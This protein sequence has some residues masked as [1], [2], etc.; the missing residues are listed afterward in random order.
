MKKNGPV[1][2]AIGSSAVDGDFTENQKNIIEF[3]TDPFDWWLGLV[4][5]FAG[6]NHGLRVGVC[7]SGGFE[8]VEIIGKLP[9]SL[10]KGLRRHA[11]WSERDYAI[12][13]VMRPDGYGPRYELH[14]MNDLLD[15]LVERKV[16]LG[17]GK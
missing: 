8:L 16:F 4:D 10:R 3:Q 5:L 17:G 15:R 12:E 6:P 9:R 14:G 7:I 13:W 2:G 1:F 11:P